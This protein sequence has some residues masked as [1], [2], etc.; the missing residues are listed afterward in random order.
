VRGCF[1]QRASRFKLHASADLCGKFV[2][3]IFLDEN[4]GRSFLYSALVGAL[5][6][7][8]P[9]AA[10]TSGAAAPGVAAPTAKPSISKFRARHL[11]HSCASEAK[12]HNKEGEAREDYV[13]ACYSREV[14]AIGQRRE[15]RAQGRAKGLNN[16]PLRDFVKQ[17]AGSEQKS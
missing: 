11:R 9:A 12:E 15:C 5:L 7:S 10:Q 8:D 1:F 4:M 3:V 16:Q 14:K 2:T 6:L 17:C 13:E